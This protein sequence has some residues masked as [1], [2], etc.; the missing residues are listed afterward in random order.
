V[1]VPSTDDRDGEWDDDSE[2]EGENVGEDDEVQDDA[3]GD[4]DI[5]DGGDDDDGDDDDDDDDDDDS[6]NNDDDDDDGEEED[7]GDDEDDDDVDDD[8][9]DDSVLVS[10]VFSVMS[11]V[12]P[13]FLNTHTVGSFHNAR[14]VESAFKTGSVNTCFKL[15]VMNGRD[16][17]RIAVVKSGYS[18]GRW[19]TPCFK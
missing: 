17:T 12:R 7:E 6:N 1:I 16:D 8:V 11:T 18:I 2:D 10:H 9:D 5:S 19:S 14:I 3:D 15:A 13:T 4:D